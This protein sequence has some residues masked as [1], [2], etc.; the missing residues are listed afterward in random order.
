MEAGAEAEAGDAG[1]GGRQRHCQLHGLGPVKLRRL[2]DSHCVQKL[3]KCECKESEVSHVQT[4]YGR[5]Q[6]SGEIRLLQIAVMTKACSNRIILALL[7]VGLWVYFVLICLDCQP[8]ISAIKDK[9]NISKTAATTPRPEDIVER[10]RTA[11]PPRDHQDDDD[12]G[13]PEDEVRGWSVALLKCGFDMPY[14]EDGSKML[15]FSAQHPFS[16]LA[17]A[18]FEYANNFNELQ[19]S[20]GDDV[21]R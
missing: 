15:R 11:C 9:K 7:A 17:R 12:P 2:P 6:R 16:R 14:D 19:G 4:R 3:Q 21:L 5:Q 1:Q 10:W 20:G 18:Y 13:L 8:A